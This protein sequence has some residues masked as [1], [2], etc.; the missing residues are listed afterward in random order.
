MSKLTLLKNWFKN[1]KGTVTAFSGGVDSSLVLYVSNLV[2]GD[3]AIGLI[4]NSESL[5]SKDYE[6]ATNFC[7]KHNIQLKVIKTEEL[8]DPNYTS[9]PA[10]RCFFCKTHLYEAMIDIIQEE[11]PNHTILNGTNLDDLGDYR[12]GLEAAKNHHIKSPL[13]EL[14]I[15]KKEV[16]E[17]AN[18]LG[19]ETA[20]KPPSPC[21]SSRIPYGTTVNKERLQQIE[22]AEYILNQYGFLN[23]RVRHLKEVASIE[24]PVNEIED[25]KNKF[26]KI[27][28]E[29]KKLG[30]NKVT[31]DKEGFVSGKLNR[32]LNG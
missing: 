18:E 2:L 26:N 14:K 20:A 27:S 24:V 13:A 25:L 6:I 30:F 11:Y 10:N 12:P 7:K 29:I 21:L 31:M 15:T 19:L 32:V 4:S 8:S 9:N 3:Q 22:K 28:K 1:H 17:M 23:V 5:K 16:I